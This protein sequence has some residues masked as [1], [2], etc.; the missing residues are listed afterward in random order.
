[1]TLPS[2]LKRT[3]A[4][5][6]LALSYWRDYRKIER[7]E[8]QKPPDAEQVI[9]DIYRQGGVRFR[10]E[11]LHLQGLIIKVGQ[12]LSART[13]VLPLAFTKELQQ[14]QDQVPA[15]PFEDIRE[16]IENTF[17]KPL[18][19]I[20]T[21]FEPVP[22]AAASL[23][24]V[25]KARLVGTNDRVAVKVQRP[26]IRE[27]AKTD[28]KAL[29]RVMAFLRRW[30]K[31]GRRIDTVKLFEEFRQSVY[32]EL[33]YIQEQEHL[34]RFKKN[35][36]DWP[37]IKVP[38][39]YPDYVHST[40]LVMEYVEGIKLTDIEEL[41]QHELNPHQL[42]SVLIE[43]YLKQI[44]VDGFVQIDPHPG[45]FLAGFDGRLIFLDFGMMS[46]I[47]PEHIDVFGR[48]VEYALAQN[49][50]GVVDCMID[51]G[52]VRPSAN[53]EVLTRAVSVM[54]ARIAGVPLQ[55]GPALT[56]LVHDF[57]DFLYEEPLQFPAHYMFLGR[58]IGMLFGLVSTLD[59]DLDWMALL[60]DKAL[61]MINERR[62]LWDNRY[63]QLLREQVERLFGPTG[64]LLWDRSAQ[65]VVQWG[66]IGLRLPETLDKSLSR[67]AYGAIE[68]RPDVTAILRRLDYL[69]QQLTLA[70][71]LGSAG[72]MAVLAALWHGHHL[73]GFSGIFYVAS[74][75]LA[76]IGLGKIFKLRRFHSRRRQQ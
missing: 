72:V 33:D 50:H 49:A 38:N 76:I 58:A 42:A 66:Q 21:D 68:T 14:L 28:L 35:F 75:L 73:W 39:V 26:N 9:Q 7:V 64:K 10:Q 29:A 36:S 5:F 48:L 67:V 52:F 27:L 61:P 16:L 62:V 65:K 8:R 24:Q 69:S 55:E 54:L 44:V 22:V 31:V 12:F 25:H 45:N 57:Q 2:Q 18:R 63:Y 15:A 70:T 34:L 40:V 11:A 17:H 6:R 46:D 13:D 4:I 1:M 43:A 41:R 23:G 56:A 37:M 53:L 30:T 60:K 71:L 3:L 32:R 47:V 51:L 74:G 20:F 59:P 19:E